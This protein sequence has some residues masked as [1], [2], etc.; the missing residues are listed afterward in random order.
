MPD[1]ALF[2]SFVV[3]FYCLFFYGGTEQLFRDS[4]TGWHIRNGETILATGQIP[5]VDPYSFTRQGE[6][7]FPWE[8]GAD[9][10]MGY[11]HKHSN[12]SGI[13]LLYASLIAVATWL[14]FQLNWRLNGNFLLACALASPMLSTTNLHWLARPH[15]FSWVFLLVLLI[16]AET[17]PVQFRW[18]DAIGFALFSALW[19]NMH[20]SFFLGPV[21][22]LIYAAG[23]MVRPLIWNV[24][25]GSQAKWFLLAAASLAAG[26]LANPFGPALHIHVFTY[27]NDMELLRRVGEFQS[28]NFHVEGAFQIVLTLGI[29]ALGGF[30]ALSSRKPHHFLLAIMFCA[31]ALRSARGLPLVAL[32]LLPVANGAITEALRRAKGLR[33]WLRG[34]LDTTM[35]Y[36]DRLRAIDSN[37]RGYALIPAV[38]LLAFIILHAP[39]VAARTG[40]PP[41]EFPVA[42]AAEIEKLPEN[43][44]LLAPDKFGG[45]L[46]YRF[47]GRR[48][49]YFDGRSDFYGSTFMK[50]YIKLVEVRPGWQEQIEKWKFTHALLPNTYSLIP[51]LEQAGWKRLY[52][53]ASVT[54]LIRNL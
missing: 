5:R 39:A 4:D 52:R 23:W 19:A 45:Y 38:L 21:I 46:I 2:V 35:D 14:W 26:S 34:G 30:V 33:P 16:R 1:V 8:W 51:A 43:A 28:F 6:P 11:V 29:A 9:M 54:L 50:E 49:V 31:M 32:L 10:L 12:L 27:L 17:V 40:F 36:C 18:R 20:G 44:R 25:G 24:G 7:W 41:S 42:A 3:L 37:L 48:K 15:I 13:S 47:A 53:D 22:A